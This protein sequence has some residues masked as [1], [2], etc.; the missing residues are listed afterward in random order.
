MQTAANV[1]IGL[2]QPVK[3]WIKHAP[4]IITLAM[5]AAMAVHGRIPDPAHYHAFADQSAAFGIPHAA[6]VSS[7]LGFARG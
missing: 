1:P 3:P 4:T 5:I 7:N 2:R 6:D